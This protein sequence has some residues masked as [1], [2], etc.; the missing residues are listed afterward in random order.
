MPNIV[1][2]GAGSASFSVELIRDI[3]NTDGLA[4]S[5]L[6]LVDIDPER[7]QVAHTLAI[8]LCEET[9]GQL[10][11]V[12]V[13]DRREA[14]VGADFVISAVKVGGY[15]PLEEERK[16]A[17]QA[18]Y[19]RGIGDR[20]S[21]YYGGIGAYHQ[22]RFLMDLARDMQ[23][24]CPEAWLIQTANPVFDGTNLITRQTD[25]KTVGVCHGHFAFA[26]VA[27][28]LGLELEEIESEM[29]GF[30]H[31]IFLTQFRYRGEDAYPLLDRWIENDSQ[32]VWHDGDYVE[33]MSPGAIDAYR[34]YG[35]FPIGDAT[36]CATPWWH[37]VSFEEKK[38]WYGNKGG[39]DSEIGWG[40]YLDRKPEVQE[41]MVR[42]AKEPGTSL[43]EEFPPKRH[44]E[45]HIQVID[46]I[47]NDQEM[48]LQLNV[49]NRGAIEGIPDDVLVEIPVVVN[50]RGI[51]NVSVGPLPPLILNNVLLPRLARMENLHDA[52]LRGDRR[53]LLLSLMDDPR[54]RTFA[55]ARDLVDTILAQ[56]WNQEADKH[57]RMK[58]PH[59]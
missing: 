12:A 34:L 30:N 57:Y 56:P 25:L 51:Q 50:G 39:F 28:T 43:L 27:D 21:C 35:L 3:V 38:R 26:H 16:I 41:K 19:Y 46:A 9:G 49:P 18:G 23:E 6:A 14:L 53:P 4:G 42:L 17:E 37:H 59:A 32:A 11:L 54:T 58:K 45:Q 52:F 55:Q 13:T 24:L 1:L 29:A 15:G 2:I 8:R 31:Y 10:E 47:A 33:E 20:V 22:F 5:T 48:H 44:S 7:L 40:E 36:R